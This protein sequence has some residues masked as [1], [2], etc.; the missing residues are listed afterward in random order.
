MQ[1]PMKV[2]KEHCSIIRAQMM[3]S[4]TSLPSTLD[5]N[6]MTKIKELRFR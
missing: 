1:E 2:M 4:V 6:T 3:E 5:A